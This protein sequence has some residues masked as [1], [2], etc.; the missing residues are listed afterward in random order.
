MYLIAALSLFFA[1][2]N[3]FFPLIF[4]LTFGFFYGMITSVPESCNNICDM[5]V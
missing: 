2:Y 5:R 3:S 1:K 4:P